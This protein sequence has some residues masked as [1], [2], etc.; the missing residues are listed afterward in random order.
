MCTLGWKIIVKEKHHKRN[1]TDTNIHIHGIC[2]ARLEQVEVITLSYCG[3]SPSFGTKGSLCT[4]NLS[5][6]DM[7]QSFS[8]SFYL[9]RSLGARASVRDTSGGADCMYLPCRPD[10]FPPHLLEDYHPLLS[11]SLTMVTNSHTA[12]WEPVF[13][14]LMNARPWTWNQWILSSVS[15]GKW[16][17]NPEKSWE[18]VDRV[19]E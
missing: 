3:M 13:W 19:A 12:I 1:I 16:R 14:L 11:Q 6:N 18:N 9:Y 2:T 4:F 10:L 8:G 5:V 15:V 17:Q 7:Y